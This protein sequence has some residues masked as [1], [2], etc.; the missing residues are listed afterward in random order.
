MT[1]DPAARG[2]AAAALE[3]PWLAE[4]V[5]SRTNTDV[6][7]RQLWGLGVNLSAQA[8][9]ELVRVGRTDVKRILGDQKKID[10]LYYA[11]ASRGCLAAV[12]FLLPT[13]YNIDFVQLGPA[14][15]ES[16]WRSQ[17]TPLQAAATAG[18]LDVVETILDAGADIN[19][20]SSALR[21]AA[22]HG[23]RAVVEMLIDAGADV[24]PKFAQTALQAAAGAGRCEL[25]KISPRMS[26]PC[27]E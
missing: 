25:V 27:V 2:S 17:C 14:D 10:E 23:H 1:V 5:Y 8:T 7:R 11:A 12:R 9:R 26:M 15:N 24:N 13:V 21:A 19:R 16:P 22:K 3:N 18:Y 6:L 4:T 20:L